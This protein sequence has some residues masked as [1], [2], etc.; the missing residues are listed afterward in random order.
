MHPYGCRNADTQALKGQDEAVHDR[1]KGLRM[2]VSLRYR[3][4]KLR[5][6]DGDVHLRALKDEPA[7]FGGFR[8][9]DLVKIDETFGRSVR[10]CE[11]FDVHI[12]F[13]LEIVKKG[14]KTGRS[15]SRRLS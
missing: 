2:G 6:I 9:N 11:S 8:R 15:P 7:V 13:V 4:L 1:N 3:L 12:E 5:S 10:V 14:T